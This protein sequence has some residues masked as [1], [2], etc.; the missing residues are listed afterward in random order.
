MLAPDRASVAP[1]VLFR[2]PLPEMTAEMF[3]VPPLPTAKVPAPPN[4]SPPPLAPAMVTVLLA[5]R[6]IV[7][8]APSVAVVPVRVIVV[9]VASPPRTTVSAPACAMPRASASR[10]LKPSAASPSLSSVVWSTVMVLLVTVTSAV[11]LVV[12]SLKEKRIVASP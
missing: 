10:K 12:P 6:L 5:S 3:S 2:L 8:P 9:L 4:A 11:V 1:L 7:S